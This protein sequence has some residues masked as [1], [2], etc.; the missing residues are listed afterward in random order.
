MEFCYSEQE[1]IRR[2]ESVVLRIAACKRTLKS[3]KVNVVA[4]ARSYAM[5]TTN[6]C[7]CATITSDHARIACNI[8]ATMS[9][10]F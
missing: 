6:S 5:F 4:V 8:V 2:K 1:Y 10:A 3:A 7:R 9:R